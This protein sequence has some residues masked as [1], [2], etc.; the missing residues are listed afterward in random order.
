VLAVPAPA[1]NAATVNA[2]TVKPHNVKLYINGKR[3]RAM[4]LLNGADE[5]YP[6]KAGMLKNI[7]ARWQ[8]DARGTGYR[9][10]ME[11]TE[12]FN[13]TYATCS[14]GTT[15]RVTKPVFIQSSQEMAWKITVVKGRTKVVG[16]ILVCLVG[17]S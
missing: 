3:Q 14:S 9:V 7:V 8:G 10:I 11:T 16:G 12:P 15:C 1:D 4:A 13:V 6:I 17:K 5:Y 2:A